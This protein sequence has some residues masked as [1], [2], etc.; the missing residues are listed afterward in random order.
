VGEY[1]YD[2]KHA[3][4]LN[5]IEQIINMI[6]YDWNNDLSQLSNYYYDNNVKLNSPILIETIQ[7]Q[8]SLL[9]EKIME[10]E[11]FNNKNWLDLGCGRGKLVNHIKQLNPKYYLG[12][13]V[14]I[15]QL[16]KALKFHDQNQNVY[17]FIPCNLGANWNDT[18]TK[19]ANINS[20]TK[21]D[22]V[23]AN[24]SLM[25]FCTDDFWS[26]LNNLVHNETKFLFNIVELPPNSNQW[27]ESNSYLKID[28][29]T[30]TYKFEWVHGEEKTE[31]YIPEKIIRQ[32]L[33][34]YKWEV[35][36]KKSTNSKYELLNF[37]SW[38]IV[39]K[40]DQ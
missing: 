3:N 31:P 26:Q 12:L 23:V 15:K 33:E 19:W 9:D 4:P 40:I 7:S 6:Q 36:S 14:D 2:K 32:Y 1:R 38:W 29:G 37:Y 16:V 13:D 5:I 22:Y 10:M 27:K 17:N 30:T 25:H 8:N 18:Q 20:N 21:F 34:K 35:I 28:E 11:P 24:F 39:K